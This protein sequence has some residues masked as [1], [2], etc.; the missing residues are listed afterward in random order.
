MLGW[1]G[2]FVLGLVWRRTFRL[3]HEWSL[4]P[5]PVKLP[6]RVIIRSS[7]L[8]WLCAAMDCLAIACTVFLLTEEQMYLQQGTLQQSSFRLRLKPPTLPLTYPSFADAPYCSRNTSCTMLH[9]EE[10][11]S[12]YPQREIFVATRIQKRIERRHCRRWSGTNSTGECE[13]WSWMLQNNTNTY[14]A[15][16]EDFRLR[17]ISSVKVRFGGFENDPPEILRLFSP[18]NR[19]AKGKIKS[20]KPAAFPA[21]RTGSCAP[22]T[23]SG[24]SSLPEQ[25]VR[26]LE[27]RSQLIYRQKQLLVCSQ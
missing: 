20:D 5:K 14:A 16:I 1:L 21:V 8:A 3:D 9:A 25:P 2:P 27:L 24:P 22:H 7:A 18:H 10:A 12:N 19:D 6:R 23:C 17:V 26:G 13:W 15:H 4:T 11:E